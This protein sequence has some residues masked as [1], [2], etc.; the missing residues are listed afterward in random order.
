MVS[1]SPTTRLSDVLSRETDSTAT[2]AGVTVTIQVAILPPS[3]VV[4]VITAEPAATALTV[5][6]SSTVATEVLLLDQVTALSSAFSG[7]TAAIRVVFSPT[8]KLSSVLSKETDSTW[9][10]A[11]SKTT[12]IGVNCWNTFLLIVRVLVLLNTNSL[13]E[14]SFTVSV[15]PFMRV[16]GGREIQKI[17][18]SFTSE[19]VPNSIA[20]SYLI[21]HEGL[22]TSCP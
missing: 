17:L 7:I 22:S 1:V 2:V 11:S 6:S 8:F 15:Y 18:Q 21:V 10:T 19:E 9:T 3:A 16:T 20:G 13:H 14:I 12:S 5:P 4:A